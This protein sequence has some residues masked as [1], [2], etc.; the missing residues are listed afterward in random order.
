MQQHDNAMRRQVLSLPQLIRDQYSDLEPK[1]RSILSIPEIFSIRK[2]LLTGC[3]DS[4]AAAVAAKQAF[5][6]LTGVP[7]EVVPTIELSRNFESSLLGFAPNNPLIIAISNS[8][9]IARVGEAAQ[10]AV[11]HGAFVLGI[12]GNS[13]SLLGTSSTRVLPLDIPSYESAPGIRTYLVSVLTLLLLAIRIGEVR[14]RYTMDAAT[15]YR[16]DLVRQSDL[17]DQ[18]LPSMDADILK[19]ADQW[20]ELE[21]FDFIGSGC[22]FA[23]AM[24]GQAKIFEAVGKY[25]MTANT[26]EW[27]HLN[28]FMRRV[29]QIGTIIVCN[30]RNASGSRAKELI[31]YA[32]KELMRPLLVVTDDESSIS[33]GIRH[34]LTPKSDYLHSGMLSQF[35]PIALLAGYIGEMIGEEDGRGCRDNWSFAENGAAV[36][37]SEIA[38][39]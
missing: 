37:N 32:S 20:K 27:L 8:G 2:I 36:K 22:D 11:Q 33:E 39:L 23:T 25:A 1:T 26:E 35:V 38:I 31:G 30:S 10:R 34:V 16:D 5:E 7:T 3:G 24:Y 4:H 15:S 28:F 29:E 19:L 13:Q 18:M 6:K 21:A 17:L 12:T 9:Y 14:G